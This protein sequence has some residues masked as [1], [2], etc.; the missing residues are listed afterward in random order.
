MPPLQDRTRSIQN[1]DC[2]E[3]AD[4]GDTATQERKIN[5]VRLRSTNES[6]PQQ[7][8]SDEF[9]NC[10]HYEVNTNPKAFYYT[11]DDMQDTHMSRPNCNVSSNPFS[12]VSLLLHPPSSQSS[13]FEKS[14]QS[15]EKEDLLELGVPPDNQSSLTREASV[16]DD[17]YA[18]PDPFRISL[19]RSGRPGNTRSNA[20]SFQPRDAIHDTVSTDDASSH[21]DHLRFPE[22]FDSNQAEGRHM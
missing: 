7:N 12:S 13:S 3:V 21:Y 9:L 20:S 4:F 2:D 10:E 15:R 16:I 1:G 5:F 6:D 11:L 19:R 18:R 8:Q 14:S 17:L 22:G